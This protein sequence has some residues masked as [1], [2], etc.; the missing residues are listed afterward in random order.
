MI[1]LYS[2]QVRFTNFSTTGTLFGV[3]ILATL[4]LELGSVSGLSRPLYIQGETESDLT[5][6][7][8][9]ARLFRRILFTNR[10]PNEKRYSRE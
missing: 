3:L 1:T 9:S 4:L 7:W 2:K 10:S 5:P 6:D 8:S